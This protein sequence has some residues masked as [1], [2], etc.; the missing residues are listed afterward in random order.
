M[1]RRLVVAL[2]SGMLA[3][4]GLLAVTPGQAEAVPVPGT[5]VFKTVTQTPPRLVFSAATAPLTLVQEMEDV[6]QWEVDSAK[7][8][9]CIPGTTALCRTA[10]DY[11]VIP[12]YLSYD[13]S[14]TVQNGTQRLITFSGNIA[15]DVRRF[16][17]Y[18]EVTYDRDPNPANVTPLTV[19]S[20]G[21]Q[22][23]TFRSVVGYGNTRINVTGPAIITPG[24]SLTL[25]GVLDCW[26]PVG[27]G[28]Y[29]VPDQGGVYAE[30]QLPG[31]T[32]WNPAQGAPNLTSTGAYTFVVPTF[33]ATADW[34]VIG[35]GTG[36]VEGISNTVHVEAGTLPP[37]P[38]PPLPTAPG[39]TLVGVTPTTATLSWTPSTGTGITGYRVGWTSATGIPVPSWSDVYA[40]PPNPFVFTNLN[41]D[42]DYVTYIEAVTTGGTGP[43]TTVT[44]RTA[45][46]P[47]PVVVPPPP[48]AEKPGAVGGA[49]ATVKQKPGPKNL[50]K[51]RWGD[52]AS[53]GGSAITGFVVT[54]LPGAGLLSPSTHK[55]KALVRQN[56]TYNL[57]VRACNAVGCGP[58]ST[59]T[60][61]A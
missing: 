13:A 61:R 23:N 18:V 41:P 36:C 28:A 10:G 4:G 34:R 21:P 30:Y 25:S 16:Y 2:I 42:S 53:N 22:A 9:I 48:G 32:T 46:A 33:G 11:R 38:P 7:V 47:P 37:P 40:S 24:A 59:V 45:A 19:R 27:Q 60:I 55:L 35:Y 12:T 49:G 39:W 44:L 56:R 15:N 5:A 26:S 43:R 1:P 31:Q 14:K 50:V 58:I 8:Y 51:F 57:S 20:Y 29:R 3:L 17:Y 54:G 52:A 6:R